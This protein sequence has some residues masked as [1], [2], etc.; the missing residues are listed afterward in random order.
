MR[1]H[2]GAGPKIDV[3]AA[4]NYAGADFQSIIEGV[5]ARNLGRCQA[6]D[7]KR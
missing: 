5:W 4:L 6:A 3:V 7:T 2:W 1:I